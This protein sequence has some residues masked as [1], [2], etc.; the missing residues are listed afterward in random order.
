MLVTGNSPK[1]D[2]ESWSLVFGAQGL[3]SEAHGF[4]VDWEPLRH[5][6]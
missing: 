5:K 3:L 2:I 1:L 4:A 6:N